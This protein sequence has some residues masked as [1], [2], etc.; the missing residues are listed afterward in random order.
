MA[1]SVTWD[2][3]RQLAEFRTSKGC[4]I[5]LYL[6]LHPSDSPTAGDAATRVNSLVDQGGKSNGANRGEQ[7]HEERVALR[8]DFE[9]IRHFFTEEFDRDGAQGFALFCAGLDNV[10]ETLPLTEPVPDEIKIGR[11]LYLAPLVPLVGRGEGAV[12][13]HIGRELG[14]LYRLRSG[15]LQEIADLSEEQPGQHD[16]GG[17]SQA[18]F[19]RR[20]DELAKN[21][22]RTVAGELER[23][24]RRLRYPAVVIVCPEELKSEFSE[25]LAGDTRNAIIGWTVAESHASATDLYNVAHPVLEQW[26]EQRESDVVER[27]KEEAGRD[28]RASAGWERT[29][30]SA[31]DGR[32][33]CLIFQEGVEHSACRCPACGRVSLHGGRCPLDGTEMEQ[34]DEGL[35][36][37]VHQVLAHG[38]QVLAL[39][40]RADLEPVG[41][42]GAILRY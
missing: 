11:E 29:L 34:R 25:L 41:G 15:R 16:Q 8:E 13:A 4:A 9:R 36:L 20:I 10:W 32:V 6:D 5:S 12:I 2:T 22:L 14:R 26:R 37:A 24:L 35:D 33:E 28:G 40:H 7:T 38:G 19:Q 42:I 30:E 27:W 18:R 23:Q 31:S 17:W 3:L 21:H 39:R 1:S